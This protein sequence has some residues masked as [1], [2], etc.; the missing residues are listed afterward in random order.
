MMDFTL[1]TKIKFK[2]RTV[3]WP[4][5][6]VLLVL[7]LCTKSA[8]KS[9]YPSFCFKKLI[10]AELTSLQWLHRSFDLSPVFRT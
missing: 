5:G 3:G 1:K 9:T 2:S 7:L 8:Q 4:D 10:S 6:I